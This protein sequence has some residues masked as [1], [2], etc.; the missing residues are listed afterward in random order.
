MAKEVENGVGIG[1]A[2]CNLRFERDCQG[3]FSLRQASHMA[4]R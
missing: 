3:R 4:G 1:T 2:G